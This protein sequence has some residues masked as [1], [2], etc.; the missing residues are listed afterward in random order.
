MRGNQAGYE[1][2]I[3]VET[4][5]DHRVAQMLTIVG[6]RCR[7]GLTILNAENVNKSYPAFFDDMISLGAQIRM[8]SE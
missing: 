5:H 8:E 6:L 4:H 7:Q 1:G 3:A 2:G